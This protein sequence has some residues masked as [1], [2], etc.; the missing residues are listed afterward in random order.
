MDP[1]KIIMLN[2][3]WIDKYICTIKLESHILMPV[4]EKQ[5]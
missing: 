5:L 3:V 2:D 4:I 1:A